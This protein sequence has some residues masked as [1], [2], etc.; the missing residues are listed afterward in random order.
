MSRVFHL[1]GKIRAVAPYLATEDQAIEVAMGLS[2]R[3][4]EGSSLRDRER[5]LPH[6]EMELVARSGLLG[7]TVP[8]E[9]GGADISNA[10]LAEVIAI[11]S[12]ADASVGQ[13]PQNHF[14]I[15][16]ALR[17]S[18]SEEQRKYFF[19]RALA[20]EHFGNALA[21]SGTK[22]AGDIETR[23][24]ADGLGYRI[25]G[26]KYY[27]TGALFADW[28]AVF[29]LDPEGK[30]VMAIVPRDAEGLS[31]V[32]DW[33]GFGQRTTASGTV[34][35][36]NV[37]VSPDSVISYYRSFERHAPLGSLGQLLHAAVDLG[38]ARAAFADMIGFVR[39][40]SRG[41]RNVGVETASADPLTIARTGSIAV[42]LEAA[43]A[44]LER[45]GRKVDV[46]QINPS[47]ETAIA[48]SLSVAAAK[49]LTTEAALDATNGLFEL[50]GTSATKEDL[51]LDRHWRNART[52]TVHD[53]VRWKHHAI[54]DFH[55]NGN[56]P[57]P[58][59]QF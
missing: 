12:E 41:I 59:G 17:L 43:S 5:L 15:L 1:A 40:K 25:T 26:R 51:N 54:G 47:S 6:D 35:I 58:N 3:I 11:L 14:S 46:A 10:F 48:A 53:P 57:R 38:I 29:G 52:H 13:I 4:A 44:V 23:L 18:G 36:D 22:A 19:A 8:A 20:G 55:L 37:Y 33:D 2:A 32:D 24:V 16:E 56:V 9:Y 30:A 49:I 21:E 39:S 28:V 45:A 27:S 7:I 31:I 50:A 34:V 42:K